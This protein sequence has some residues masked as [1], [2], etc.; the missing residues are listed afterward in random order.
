M[1]AEILVAS[2]AIILATFACQMSNAEYDAATYCPL[3]PVGTKFP[4]FQ[5]CQTFYTCQANNKVVESSCPGSDVFS[6]DAQSCVSA[7]SANC[8]NDVANPCE[9]K[10]GTWVPDSRDCRMWHYCSKGAIAGSGSCANGQ[11]FDGTAGMCVNGKCPNSGGSTEITNLC[12]IMQNNQFFGDFDNCATWHKC[13]GPVMHTA[14]CNKGL[15]YNA[16]ERM[17]L[18]SNGNMCA[19]P[20]KECNQKANN[21]EVANPS[22]CSVYFQCTQANS[23]WLWKKIQCPIGQYYDL[24]SKGCLNRQTATPIKGCNRCEF[25]TAT[26]VNA[27]DPDCIEFLT[28]RNGQEVGKGKCPV[29]GGF[30]N[31]QG[32]MCM[33][34]DQD[35]PEYRKN[36]GACYTKSAVAP[37]TSAPNTEAPTEDPEKTEPNPTT[38]KS[39]KEPTTE[40]HATEPATEKPTTEKSEKE[41][42]TEKSEKEP[43]TEKHA[44]EP[45]TEKPTTEK[46]EKEPTTEKSEKEP[47][48]EKHATEPATEKHTTEKSATEPVT[49]E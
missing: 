22:I 24:N 1:N 39:E 34:N 15:I 14:K 8:Y 12:Q 17:C 27:V 30:F 10:D 32:Q 23:N 38:E 33:N 45:A 20:A 25:T 42:T 26:W 40:K 21:E 11:Y 28:C 44:T 37:P 3:V 9:N 6:K 49:K 48:T 41:P 35:L 4:S 5:S 18:A 47:T 7:S 2:V 19:G 43:T 13:S 29:V 46:S 16:E 31:E 36:N